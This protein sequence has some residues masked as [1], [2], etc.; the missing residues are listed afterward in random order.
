MPGSILGSVWFRSVESENKS[1]KLLLQYHSLRLKCAKFNF[2]CDSAPDP[3]GKLTALPQTPQLD[4]R[5][6]TSKAGEGMKGKGKI[7]KGRKRG[8]E[9][10]CNGKVEG[11]GKG[12]ALNNFLHTPS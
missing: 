8:R 12:R 4:L 3:A 6:L 11:V 2:S 1:L 7:G 5:G 9:C 10:M